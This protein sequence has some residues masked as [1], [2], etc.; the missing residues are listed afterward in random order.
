MDDKIITLRPLTRAELPVV[1]AWFEDHDTSRFLGGRDWPTKMLDHAA[2]C[3]GETF[4]GATQTGS[5]HYLAFAGATPV[6]YTDCGTFDRCTVYGGE[7][8]D[9]PIILDTIDAATGAFAFAV[10]PAHRRQGLATRMIWTLTQH[11]DLATVEL[12]EAGVVPDNHACRRTL[13]AAGF[14]LRS[15]EPDFEEM[16]YYRAWK[17]ATVERSQTGC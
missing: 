1:E 16:L 11:S 12:F 9:G 8:P 3:V 2:R 13:E 5:H 15:Q 4:R 7:G 14:T 17:P 10:D 6:G